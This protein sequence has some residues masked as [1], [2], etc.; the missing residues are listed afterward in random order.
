MAATKLDG[1]GA[2]KMKTLE[3]ALVTLQTLHGMVE[4]MAMEVQNQR[5]IG[6][7]PQQL[8]RLAAPLVGQLKGQFGM[9]ADQLSTM[10]LVAG[11]GGGEKLKVRAYREHVAQIR[12]ALEMAQSKVKKD[13]GVEI[14]LAP[15]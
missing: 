2:Q 6:V 12:T 8:K 14:E 15:E 9:I 3:E 1:A 7:M 11:R 10:L 4:R 13:H 5:P